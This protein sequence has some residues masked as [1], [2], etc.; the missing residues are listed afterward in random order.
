[1]SWRGV[2]RL[3]GAVAIFLATAGFLQTSQKF[4][5][6]SASPHIAAVAISSPAV[7]LSSDPQSYLM[8]WVSACEQEF[9]AHGHNPNEALLR[10]CTSY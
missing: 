10:S 6:T 8:R 2:V 3:V 4:P 5:V 9:G 1:M 7:P